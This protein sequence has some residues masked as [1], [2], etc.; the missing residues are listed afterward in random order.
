MSN[1]IFDIDGT[2]RNFEPKPNI[3][4]DLYKYLLKLKERNSLYVVTGRTYKNYKN[5]LL[6]LSQTMTEAVEV[7]TL[8][9]AIFCEDGHICYNNDGSNCLIDQIAR[10]QL[11]KTRFYVNK[12]LDKV[13][14]KYHIALPHKDLVSEIT[15]TIQEREGK[16]SFKRSLD[17]FIKKNKVDK[18]QVNVLTHNR[19]SV[20]VIGI[21]KHSAIEHYPLDLSNSSYFCDERNDLEL[22]KRIKAVSGIVICPSNAIDEIKTISDYVSD[23]PYSYGVVDYL[24]KYFKKSSN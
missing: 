8:F 2:L 3:N 4:P 20:S 23:L 9:D 11:N 21:G 10:A 6:E 1:F 18:L 22:A 17:A 24:S 14:K 12:Y 15:I 7:D 16:N 19:L 13:N 5:F